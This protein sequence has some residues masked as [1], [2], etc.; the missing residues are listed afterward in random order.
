MEQYGG[1]LKKPKKAT[2]TKKTAKTSTKAKKAS[3]TSSRKTTKTRSKAKGGNFLGTVGDLVAPTGWGPFATAAGLLALDR[4]DAALRRGTKEK[5]MKGGKKM[6]GGE[7]KEITLSERTIF[8]NNPKENDSQNL[9]STETLKNYNFNNP[10]YI[11][12]K[13]LSE[14]S[15][16][17]LQENE[18][19]ISIKIFCNGDYKTYNFDKIV[20]TSLQDAKKWLSNRHNQLSLIGLALNYFHENCKNP[21]HLSRWQMSQLPKQQNNLSQILTHTSNRPGIRRTIK[22]Q[23]IPIS[24]KFPE[25]TN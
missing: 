20:Y 6:T 18:Y 8:I 24:S 14:I 25:P 12:N 1:S 10:K 3:T 2:K 19:K 22:G 13:N 23:R 9:Q 15:I 4:A 16:N 11:L 7:C 21:N 17:C 5:K